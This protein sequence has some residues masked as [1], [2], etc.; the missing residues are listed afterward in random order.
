MNW[1]NNVIDELQSRILDAPRTRTE[2]QSTWSRRNEK[3]A[4]ERL[5]QFQSR[6][7]D[8]DKRILE[9]R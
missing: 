2:T 9:L 7:A 3:D 4:T 6:L 5:H 8:L 1:L